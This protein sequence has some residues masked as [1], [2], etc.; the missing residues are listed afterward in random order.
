MLATIIPLMCKDIIFLEDIKPSTRQKVLKFVK[1]WQ[2][3]DD[4]LEVST[5]GS[6]GKPKTIRLDKN[7]MKA[8]AKATVDFF[9]LKPNQTIL[10]AMSTDYIAGK[11]MLVRALEHQL[12]IIVAPVVSNPLKNIIPYNIDFSAFVPMQVNAILSD[13]TSKTNYENI[14][15]VII[16]GA[17]ISLQL[18]KQLQALKNNN[19]STFGMTETISH[20]ALKNISEKD[21]FYTAL[22]QVKFSVNQNN[23]LIIEAPYLLNQPIVTNDVVELL[24]S[25]Q[26]IW[27]GRADFVI[28][29][30]GIKLHPELIEKKIEPFLPKHQFYLTSVKD[31]VLGQ[32]LILKVEGVSN[33][34]IKKLFIN[35]EQSL[36]KFEMPKQIINVNH[37][38]TTKTGKVIR[39]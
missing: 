21:S 3:N 13:E 34:E 24:T 20:I 35:L 29:S 30:G 31:I 33:Q 5:S 39:E 11:M 16:G 38:K 15:Q 1:D 6:T 19:Y 9:N 14:N 17:P 23:Q 12:N 32:K 8:S 18:E 26:F 4:W 27:K 2:S 36:S 10:L 7:R 28:N 25:T 37:F 22:P